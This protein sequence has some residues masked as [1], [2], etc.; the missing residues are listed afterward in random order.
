MT[1]NN[2]SSKPVSSGGEMEKYEEKEKPTQSP[3]H[4]IEDIFGEL[5]MLGKL[6]LSSTSSMDQDD[7]GMEYVL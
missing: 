5:N 7:D 3:S 6:P 4:D 1:P 2:V